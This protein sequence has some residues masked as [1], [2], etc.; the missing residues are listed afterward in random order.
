MKAFQEKVRDLVQDLYETG[1][2]QVDTASK[3]II[4]DQQALTPAERRLLVGLVMDADEAFDVSAAIRLSDMVVDAL[5]GAEY[6]DTDWARACRRMVDEAGMMYGNTIDLE[7]R[8]AC[9]E[10]EQEVFGPCGMSDEETIDRTE[11][12]AAMRAALR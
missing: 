10:L 5:K 2:A 3:T 4:A 7:M 9:E 6:T 8:D 11:R 12:A 1:R